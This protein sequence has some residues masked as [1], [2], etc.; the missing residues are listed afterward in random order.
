MYWAVSEFKADAGIEITASHNPIEYNGMKIVKNGSQPL[1][2][3][4]F[5]EIKSLTEQNKFLYC[6]QRGSVKNKSKSAR[7]AYIEKLISFIDIKRLKP[8]KV[9]INSGNGAAG[10]AIDALTS[11]LEAK[12]CEPNFVKLHNNPDSSF[13]WYSQSSFRKNW[14]ATSDVVKAENADFGVAFDG[15]FDRCFF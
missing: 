14:A 5:T 12:G 9:V 3:K 7:S 4:D 1:T 10:P 6:Q 15:D 13:Q 8:L 2:I 11:V